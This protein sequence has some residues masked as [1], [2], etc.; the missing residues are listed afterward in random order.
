MPELPPRQQTNN[1]EASTASGNCIDIN[2][3][4]AATAQPV[5][6]IRDEVILNEVSE[7]LNTTKQLDRG[8]S[9]Q[10]E[11]DMVEQVEL[12]FVRREEEEVV[13]EAPPSRS[14]HLGNYSLNHVVNIY[15]DMHRCDDQ[16]GSED[17]E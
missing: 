6:I 3:R 15:E 2:G 8:V 1:L 13:T 4:L 10:T 5:S 9:F 17:G 16:Q 14:L 12:A 11:D 7:P